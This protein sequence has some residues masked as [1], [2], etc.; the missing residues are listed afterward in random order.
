MFN[1]PAKF[2]ILVWLFGSANSVLAA[3]PEDNP[4]PG[5]I[6]IVSLGP[7]FTDNS[8]VRFGNNEVM[9]R[10]QGEEWFAI[11]GLPFNI[12]PGKYLIT[13][14]TKPDSFTNRQFRVNPLPPAV[15]QRTVTL[16]RLLRDL[17]FSL[18]MIYS[19]PGNKK[20]KSENR[21][22]P[23]FSFNQIVS[24]G[25]FIPYGLVL[26]GES[27][28]DV[29][30]HTG[31]TYIT[32]TDELVNSPA[33]AVVEQISLDENAGIIVVLDHGKGM[34]SV[35]TYLNDTILKPGDAVDQ[36]GLIGSARHIPELN[37][38]RVDWQLLLNGNMVDPLQF[39][40]SS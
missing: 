9:V 36:G 27:K 25:S 29:V 13:I 22:E 26:R 23:D 28:S 20:L 30:E 8:R 32:K 4:V 16:P 18:S 17:E 40:P 2:L 31:I 11:V 6:A 1:C 12:S 34:K 15:A 21:L 19:L 39:A 3:L 7:E 24:S 33:A 38:G 35:I 10:V 14:H 37:A 5:G